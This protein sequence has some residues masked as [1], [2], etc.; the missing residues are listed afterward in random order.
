MSEP[1]ARRFGVKKGD[2]LTFHTPRGPLRLTIQGVYYDYASDL[3]YFIVSRKLYGRYFP[4]PQSGL[5]NS[6]ATY[7]A[8]G[9]RPEA[10]Q[11]ELF[12]RLRTTPGRTLIRTNRELRAE[13]LRIFDRT[14][15]ITYA[16]E[17][18]ACLVAVLAVANTLFALVLENR[19]EFGILRYLGAT[20]GQLKALVLSQA[21][22]MAALGFAGGTLSG[23]CLAWLLIHVIN[24]QSFGWTIQPTLPW[25]ALALFFG[26]FMGVALLAGV[27]P[28]R[29]AGRI[30]APAV[31]RQE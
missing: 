7:L 25:Q 13:V 12:R 22:A 28:A 16:M 24:P 6:A 5:A 31:V 19:R 15:A 2:A 4:A 27:V 3:G 23:A 30:P 9:A 26:L 11:A 21:A 14:F 8:P 10:V 18:I 17:A 1:F 29:F 20:A